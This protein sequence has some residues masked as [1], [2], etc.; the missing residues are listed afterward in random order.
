MAV[1]AYSEEFYQ[2][3]NEQLTIF[4]QK[5]SKKVERMLKIWTGRVMLL[6]KAHCIF[7]IV[8][9]V[10]FPINSMYMFFVKDIKMLMIEM[11]VPFV[12]WHEFNGFIFTS[13][14]QS[15]AVF[16]S[17]WFSY[18]V[19][20]IFM[21]FCFM[22]S[23]NID[24]LKLRYLELNEELMQAGRNRKS[25]KEIGQMFNEIIKEGVLMDRY[26]LLN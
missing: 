1:F 26:Y 5:N 4:Q 19:D 18:M 2:R 8:G 15:L 13:L 10:G 17:L 9:S 11:H 12:D 6:A 23:A 14:Y 20:V 7:Y 3:F 22:T 21:L 25:D 24:Y 16:L